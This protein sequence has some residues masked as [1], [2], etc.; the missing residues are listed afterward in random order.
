[1]GKRQRMTFDITNS[2]NRDAADY[3]QIVVGTGGFPPQRQAHPAGNED[4]ESPPAWSA[5]SSFNLN[6]TIYPTPLG[7]A[8]A[9]AFRNLHFATYFS[10]RRDLF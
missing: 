10:P 9:D 5:A 6:T 2:A 8:A 1:M 7:R 3:R 4:S